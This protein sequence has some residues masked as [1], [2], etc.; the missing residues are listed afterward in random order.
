MSEAVLSIERVKAGYGKRTILRDINLSI[1]QGEWCTL[2]GPNGV[3]KTTLLQA[4]VG[5][6][7]CE[8]GKISIAGHALAQ[9]RVDALRALGFAAAPD[10]LPNLL[11]GRQCLETYAA[12]KEC[13]EVDASVLELAQELR[14]A[15]YLDQFVDTYSLGTRQKL[16]ILLALV[17]APKLLVLDEAFNGLDPASALTLKHYLRARVS[18]GEMSV[19]LA[20]HA[21]DIVE[22]FSDT[23]AL[24]WNGHIV[25]AW[26]RE[27][28]RELRGRSADALES[29]LARVVAADA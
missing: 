8:S 1:A 4:V 7:A 11:T 29:E 25:R 22:H 27:A 17:G 12:A 24:L 5:R 28:L 3:G 9:N 23:A 15:R 10:R 26:D 6:V 18:A 19:L 14:F 20:T 16:C 2:L 13:G 21:L